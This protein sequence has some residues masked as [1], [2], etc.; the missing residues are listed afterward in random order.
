MKRGMKKSAG[1]AICAEKNL[2][3]RES[4]PSSAPLPTTA[5]L[6][7]LTLGNADTF[8]LTGS[9]ACA[10]LSTEA[11]HNVAQLA[12]KASDRLVIP[13]N[14]VSPASTPSSADVV[15]CARPPKPTHLMKHSLLL[16]LTA[17]SFLVGP[18]LRATPAEARVERFT[19]S[20]RA[21]NREIKA[22]VVLPPAH[23][24][25]NGP[26][27][28]ILYALHGRAAPYDT[29]ANMPRLR[30]ALV[31]RA[32]IVAGFDAD[33]SSFYLDSPLP[34]R[35]GRE[36]EKDARVTSLFTTFFF[37]EFMPAIEARYAADPDRR[38][39]TG[40]SM[41]GFGALHYAL[42]KPD[43]FVS[44]SSMSGVFLTTFPPS[45][46]WGSRLA[47][48]L[49]SQDAN[50]HAYQALAFHP[51]IEHLLATRASLPLIYLHCGTE[52]R[53]VDESRN[54]HAFLTRIGVAHEHHESPGSH[55]WAYWSSTI[56]PVLD[57]HW[58]SLSVSPVANP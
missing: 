52:D 48:L 20:S 55:D 44:V 38:M 13:V 23:A 17:C 26:R 41:G 16:T 10:F 43:Q 39:L 24:E 5:S 35:S 14:Q 11:R 45:G 15:R 53:L 51:R 22:W 29:F 2:G 18:L 30:A 9:P 12:A 50:P 57:F 54:L 34:Q 31:S 33:A 6:N 4:L 7:L 56:T 32:M 37:D 46:G 28:P 47:S 8:G 21:M 58:K 1:C 40:F 25:N 49:G 42:T 3:L 19:V 36:P 27:L